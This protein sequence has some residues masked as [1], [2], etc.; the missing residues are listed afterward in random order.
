[1][2]YLL[3]YFKLVLL[4]TATAALY[5]VLHMIWTGALPANLVPAA[6]TFGVLVVFGL[7]VSLISLPGAPPVDKDPVPLR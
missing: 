7:I 1:M 2:S 4:L 5:P 3:G 6:L